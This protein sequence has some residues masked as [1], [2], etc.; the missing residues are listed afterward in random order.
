MGSP[1]ILSL[2]G[3]QIGIAAHYPARRKGN[4]VASN[5]SSES[6]SPLGPSI[7]VSKTLL[8]EHGQEL[9]AVFG[10][11]HSDKISGAVSAPGP[12]GEDVQG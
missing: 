8:V 7:V 1:A 2:T 11:I 12:C 5:Q 9:K 6:Q 3:H 4:Q 10:N